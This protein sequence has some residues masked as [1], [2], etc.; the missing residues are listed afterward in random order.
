MGGALDGWQAAMQFLTGYL[1]EKSLSVDNIFVIAAVFAYFRVPAHQQHR[2]LFW[3][4]LGA[5]VMRGVMIGLGAA[6]IHRFS[7]S[8]YLF[9]ALLIFSAVKMLRMK[10]D[11]IHPDRNLAVRL[12]RR[13]FR[14]TTD[15]GDG[16]F[17]VKQDG[18][19]AVTPLFLALLLV[20]TTDVM[21]AVDSIPAIFAI[22]RDPFIVFTSNIFAILGLRS[23]YFAMAGLMDK[24][25]YLKLSLVAL[26]FLV[27]IKMIVSH[28]YP[29]PTGVSLGV[30]AAVLAVGVIASLLAGPEAE[31]DEGTTTEPRESADEDPSLGA[32]RR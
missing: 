21:F 2:V 16:R 28:H 24:F 30:I 6:L 32:A 11:D 17:I 1:V 10:E 19:W 9:G 8:V 14:V 20:E 15:G 18:R 26:L 22:T 31:T 29:I 13:V 23:L 7:W 5:I 25:R 27:G 3:G 4:I 12:A